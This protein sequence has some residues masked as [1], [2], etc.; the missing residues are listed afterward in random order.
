M[1]TVIYN[2]V[3]LLRCEVL[4]YQREPIW[5]GNVDYLYTR[6]R[7][8]V[9]GIL[10]PEINPYDFTSGIPNSQRPSAVLASANNAVPVI[11]PVIGKGRLDAIAASGLGGLPSTTDQ[12]RMNRGVFAPNTDLAI[13]HALMQPRRVLVYAVGNA[14]V[15][16][17]PS[18]NADGAQAQTDAANGPLPVVY[19][20]VQI[21]GTKSFLVDFG[22]ETYLN[23]SYLYVSTP[24][25]M[26]SHRWKATETIDQDYFST[27][28]IEGHAEFRSDRLLFLGAV[29]DD[30][31]VAL[32]H[33]LP[34]PGWK[35]IHVDAFA[36][37]DGNSADYVLV[38]KQLAL[39][40]VPAGVTRIES[41]V[42][43][44]SSNWGLQSVFGTLGNALFGIAAGRGS[45]ASAIGAASSSFN[46][47]GSTIPLAELEI[48]FRVWGRSDINRKILENV[49]VNGC[50]QRVILAQFFGL[51]AST[52]ATQ[53]DVT[54]D[55]A[56]SF[57]EA[58][59]IVRT[60]FNRAAYTAT[61]TSAFVGP[62]GILLGGNP[63]GIFPSTG[64]YFP[65][66]DDTTDILTTN[67]GNV[68]PLGL[69]NRPNSAATGTRGT[70]V[71]RLTTAALLAQNATPVNPPPIFP[72][73]NS[74]VDRS[75][76]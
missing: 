38:D 66:F 23:E 44:R 55:I 21:S 75:P 12:P 58:R 3:G 51:V 31:R 26:L 47:L 30:F 49:A 28:V 46:L 76:P 15:L 59:G 17:S 32:F 20:V 5:N 36:N 40:I 7:L 69:P 27:R 34:G 60:A 25:V 9:R 4:D 73:G 35:R 54:H 74:V 64:T 53:L 37:Q 42:T 19:D 71:Q 70:F 11:N 39:S 67:H 63:S 10:N 57:V 61:G 1:S 52:A 45:S 56:G 33:P 65:D 24:S 50:R 68:T 22:V 18:I 41:Y 13:R 14:P 2:S 48:V 8:R 29:P 62:L 72:S 16:V 43:A 6:H